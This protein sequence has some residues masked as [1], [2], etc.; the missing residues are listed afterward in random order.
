[1]AFKDFVQKVKDKTQEMKTEAMKFKNKDFMHAVAASCAMVA[2]ADGSIDD[3]EKQ[4]MAKFI[5]AY[6]ALKVFKTIDVI[7]AFNDFVEQYEFSESIGEA[8]SME[9]VG[10]FRGKEQQAR[11]L[12]RICIAIGASDGDFDD[13]EQDV[14]R[15]ICNELQ[16]SPAEF[17][18]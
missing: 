3:K 7:R 1:M 18:L 15:K 12:V 6:D 17:D 8:K 11:L 5:E 2:R 14:V 9:A 4:E 10:K 16:V 13:K